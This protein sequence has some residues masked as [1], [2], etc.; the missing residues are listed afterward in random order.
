MFSKSCVEVSVGS[1]YIKCVAVGA[2]QFM[3][4]LPVVFVVLCWCKFS[5]FAEELDLERLELLC[6]VYVLYNS[7]LSD[8]NNYITRCSISTGT[9]GVH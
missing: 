6:K 5:Q 9:C 3:N 8:K 1:S 2:C 4:S 7:L